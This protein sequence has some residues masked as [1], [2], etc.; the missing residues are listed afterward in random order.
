MIEIEGMSPDIGEKKVIVFDTSWDYGM[1]A[2]VRGMEVVE[3]S[4]RCAPRA[5]SEGLLPWIIEVAQRSG[6][7]RNDIELLVVGRGP[8]SYTGTRIAVTVAKSLAEVLQVPLVSVSSVESIALSAGL[9]GQ[10]VAVM[11]D[12]KKGEI[13]VALYDLKEPLPENTD[14][15]FPVLLS[16]QQPH[17]LSSAD[18]ARWM[19]EQAALLPPLLVCGD[20]WDRCGDA[21]SS[22][23]T[24]F[25]IRRA[26]RYPLID[27]LAM[28]VL[29]YRRYLI[30]ERDLPELLEPVY[31]RHI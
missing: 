3:Q 8:G 4:S 21:L 28:V 5:A 12:A 31:L 24:I 10:R 14:D 6:W 2:A 9:P 22:D 27:P 18:A 25:S 19:K 30:G 15:G 29:S 7:K 26:D 23:G 11:M 13:M 20:G 1:V 16:R 17:L